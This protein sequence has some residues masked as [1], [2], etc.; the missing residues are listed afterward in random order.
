MPRMRRIIA[1]V[2]IVATSIVFLQY[3]CRAQR[4]AS[5]QEDDFSTWDTTKLYAHGISLVKRGIQLNEAIAVLKLAVNR[6]NRRFDYQ[7]ALGSAFASRF[8]SVA[9]AAEQSVSYL[10]AHSDFEKRVAEWE[11]AQKDPTSTGFGGP[12]PEEPAPL[13]TPDDSKRFVMQQKD[14]VRRTL[15]RLG[16]QSIAA[17]GA[18]RKLSAYS[19]AEER[20]DVEYERGWGLFLLRRFG[21]EFVPNEPLP[22][23]TILKKEELLDVRQAEVIDCFIR[24]TTLDPKIADNW[25]SLGLAY[26]PKTVFAIEYDSL[27]KYMSD[28]AINSPKED[29][30]AVAALKKALTIKPRDFNLLFQT[31]QIGY[32]IDPAL[33]VDCLDRAAQRM[34]TNAVLWYCLANHRFKRASSLDVKDPL[35]LNVRAVQDVQTGNTAPQY[36]AI[37]VVLPVPPLLKQAWQFVPSYGLTEDPIILQETWSAL[38]EFAT[39]RDMHGDAAQYINVI[40][41]WMDMGLKAIRAVDTPNSNYKHPRVRLMRWAR[42]FYG[43][44]FCL[45]AYSNVRQSQKDRP[46]DRKAA[47]LDEQ[48]D[49]IPRLQA[50]EKEVIKAPH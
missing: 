32:A 24:C 17:Y 21:R 36:W 28:V 27:R 4:G 50:L 2:V 10:H 6:D 8:A 1:A 46:D 19:S 38:R 22:D 15:L 30:D 12:I 31:A 26:V 33:A 5:T 18:A 20:R 35:G 23:R 40:A 45:D 9:C 13:R 25:H 49:L 29:S 11:A 37:P 16:R 34:S 39:D 14:E 3:R 7:L 42:V 44:Q 48:Q 47:Y 41:T 43:V